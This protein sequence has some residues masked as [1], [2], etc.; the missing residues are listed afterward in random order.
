MVMVDVIMMMM[1]MVGVVMM[2]MMMVGVRIIG[3]NHHQ[4]LAL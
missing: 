2:R 4:L 1:M 3:K